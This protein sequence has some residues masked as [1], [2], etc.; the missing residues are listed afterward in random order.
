MDNSEHLRQLDAKRIKSGKIDTIKIFVFIT[1]MEAVIPY[2]ALFSTGFQST[3]LKEYVISTAF[4]LSMWWVSF[5]F[6]WTGR[7]WVRILTAL[8]LLGFSLM[9]AVAFMISDKY[10]S[11]G[12]SLFYSVVYIAFGIFAGVALLSSTNMRRFFDDQRKQHLKK[13]ESTSSD[14]KKYPYD[15]AISF[16]GED[17]EVAE[18]LSD[19]LIELGLTV[20]YDR[21]EEHKLLGKNLYQYL[22]KIYKDSAQTCIVLI[23]QHY[24]QKPWT[25]HELEQIQAR[26]FETRTQ[27]EIEYLLPLRIDDTE[28]PGINSIT[29]YLDA[30]EKPISEVAKIVYKKIYEG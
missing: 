20:F 9:V 8:L 22:Q 6:I 13:N 21:L 11:S 17:R 30:R 23:S 26:I 16:A 3:T 19:H 24:V 14:D 1:V 15:V 18:L 10:P 29:G 4:R 25:L 5:Y 12:E 28:I 7:R 2:F 27:D